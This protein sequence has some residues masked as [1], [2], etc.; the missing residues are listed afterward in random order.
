MSSHVTALR[1]AEKS[2]LRVDA[3][4]DAGGG[5]GRMQGTKQD[6]L[7]P[8]S[9]S[10]MTGTSPTIEWL[11]RSQ[12]QTPGQNVKHVRSSPRQ[13]GSR[14]RLLPLVTSAVEWSVN[15]PAYGPPV[16]WSP[17]LAGTRELPTFSRT[18]RT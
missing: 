3:R 14:L 8:G 4:R 12:G 1:A 17:A 10:A 11:V 6:R 7:P 16:A 13:N 15:S 18:A 2:T 9:A 5:V